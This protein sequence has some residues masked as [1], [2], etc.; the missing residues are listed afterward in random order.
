MTAAHLQAELLPAL[1]RCGLL[2]VQDRH[3]PCVVTL[4]TGEVPATSWWSHPDSHRIFRALQDL[5]AHPDVLLT[6]LLLGKDTFV[7]RALWPALL[8]VAL[9]RE[10][11]Q[12]RALTHD[13]GA[14]LARTDA[15]RSAVTASGREVRELL[16]RLLVHSREVHTRS[17]RHELTLMSWTLWAHGAGVQRVPDVDGARAKLEACA[18]SLGARPGALPWQR[19]IRACSR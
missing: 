6:K 9:A 5:T 10:P 11:W 1:A 2:L 8:A 14:L 15:A 18:R 16:A 4:L 17:G 19:N 13:A 3:L 7:H 12:M